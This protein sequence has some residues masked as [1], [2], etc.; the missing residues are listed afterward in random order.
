MRIRG[1]K[2]EWLVLMGAALLLGACVR[3]PSQAVGALRIE[4]AWIRAIPPNAPAAGG[5]MAIHNTATQADRLLSAAS[6]EAARIE[7]H[8]VLQDGDVMRMR[9]MPD[10]LPIP[11]NGSVELRPGSYHLMLIAPKRRYAEGETVHIRLR[12]EHAGAA[13]VAF[14]VRSMTATAAQS[15]DEPHH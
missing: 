14:P 4:R 10:G 7:I 13:D 2:L 1:I 12:F 11:G 5:F 15:G 9:H 6:D 3:M 8:E